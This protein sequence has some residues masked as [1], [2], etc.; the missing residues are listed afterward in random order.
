MVATVP[1]VHDQVPPTVISDKLV[2]EPAH[3]DVEPIIADGN[4][5]TVMTLVTAGQP[6]IT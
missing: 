1:G 2:V 6:V 4:G 3:T 5:L